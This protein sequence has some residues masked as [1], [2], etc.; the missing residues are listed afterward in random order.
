M[1]KLFL[2]SMFILFSYYS[3]GIRPDTNYVSTPKDLGLNIDTKF[4]Q[5]KDGYKIASWLFPSM[6][7]KK[8]ITVILSYGD[9]GNMSY[10][11]NTSV[12]LANSGFDV[13]TYDYRG[14]GKS[15]PFTIDK[16]VLYYKEFLSDLE[17][18]ITLAKL[19]NPNNKICLMGLSMGSIISMLYLNSP[20]ANNISYYIGEGHI[21]SPEAIGQ[22]L[23]DKKK[24][25]ILPKDNINWKSFYSG[26][27]IPFML[28]CGS[29]DILWNEEDI[30]LIISDNNN[31]KIRRFDGGHLQGI[32]ILKD[33]Y[34]KEI[35]DFLNE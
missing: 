34:I 3:F 11:L 7:E 14:F 9:A 28:F 33:D 22:R 35:S 24:G 32:Y 27:K 13:I 15:S 21:Y 31:I 25:L 23:R 4:L 5:T 17:S 30:N 6:V 12:G 1:K 29:D 16:D 10:W 20:E 19:T 18:A 8:N 26:I 2:Y